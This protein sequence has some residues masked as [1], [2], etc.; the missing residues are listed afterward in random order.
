MQPAY[1][2][3]EFSASR[4]KPSDFDADLIAVPVFQDE[5]QSAAV[6][7]DV[8]GELQAAFARGEFTGKAC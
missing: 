4:S 5:P 6:G 1:E 7:S 8:E 2:V 3:P